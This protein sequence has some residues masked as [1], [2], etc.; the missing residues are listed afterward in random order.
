[1]FIRFDSIQV[2]RAFQHLIDKKIHPSRNR[3]CFNEAG[4]NA[5]ITNSFN[6]RHMHASN[7]NNNR[8]RILE[9][10]RRKLNENVQKQHFGISR[11]KQK[12]TRDFSL[13]L[14]VPVVISNTRHIYSWQLLKSR[15]GWKLVVAKYLNS[16]GVAEYSFS[17]SENK[18]RQNGTVD[19]RGG[20]AT[21]SPPKNWY[22][23]TWYDF[24]IFNIFFAGG[25][26]ITT[27]LSI[28]T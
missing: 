8:N 11:Y 23:I 13:K 27:W 4:I 12:R 5:S 6:Q 2:I 26:E 16:F 28:V 21:F 15:R 19:G 17:S 18:W 3:P 22:E 10:E 1:M 25:L 14:E 20:I 9:L 7:R 24:I